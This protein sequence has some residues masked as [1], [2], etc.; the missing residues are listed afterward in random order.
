[1]QHY[2]IIMLEKEVGVEVGV[3]NK[4]ESVNKLIP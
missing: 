2:I 3:H 4:L 1:M